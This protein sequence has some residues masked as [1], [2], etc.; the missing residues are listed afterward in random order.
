M[1]FNSVWNFEFS[2]NKL[3]IFNLTFKNE[4]SVIITLIN[5]IKFLKIRKFIV[6]IN[7][8]IN[9]SKEKKYFIK[10]FKFIFSVIIQISVKK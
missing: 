5:K 1:H 9:K 6:T 3:Y 7:L 2:I 8:L 10:F 4:T